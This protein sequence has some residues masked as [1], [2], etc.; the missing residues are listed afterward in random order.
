MK[1]FSEKRQEQL[2]YK[3]EMKLIWC[4]KQIIQRTQ[5]EWGLIFHIELTVKPIMT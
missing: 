4:H 3:L 1:Q 2:M 5:D